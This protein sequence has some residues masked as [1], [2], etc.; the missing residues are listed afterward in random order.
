MQQREIIGCCKSIEKMQ[1]VRL[2]G[3][4]LPSTQ[5]LPNRFQC[6]VQHRVRKSF[7]H[8]NI[9]ANS[10]LEQQNKTKKIVEKK[11]DF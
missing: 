9:K 3:I 7:L 4:Q 11:V 8:H 5:F 2:N 10:L 1:K 6:N